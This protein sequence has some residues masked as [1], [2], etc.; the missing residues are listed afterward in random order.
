[1][2]LGEHQIEEGWVHIDLISSA[3][4]GYVIRPFPLE[5]ECVGE[6]RFLDPGTII[7]DTFSFE[8]TELKGG[9]GLV[10]ND[11]VRTGDRA[12]NIFEILAH[13]RVTTTWI[14][15]IADAHLFLGLAGQVP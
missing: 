6:M 13:Q 12:S 11:H 15:R 8:A 9:V 10:L 14:G 1:M 4:Y 3:N 5:G 7:G 2:S